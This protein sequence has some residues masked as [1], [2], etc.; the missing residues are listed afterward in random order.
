MS[1]CLPPHRLT[2]V[3]PLGFLHVPSARRY[4][5]G[6]GEYRERRHSRIRQGTSHAAPRTGVLLAC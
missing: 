4:M 3:G 1:V 2:R 6:V 5:R